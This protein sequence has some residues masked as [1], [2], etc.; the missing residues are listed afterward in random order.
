MIYQGTWHTPVAWGFFCSLCE[1]IC[2]FPQK[3]NSTHVM[4][5]QKCLFSGSLKQTDVSSICQ[6]VTRKLLLLQD[7]ITYALLLRRMLVFC[8]KDTP[9]Y[10]MYFQLYEKYPLDKRITGL[11]GTFGDSLVW[12]IC[13]S[14]VS[15]SRLLWSMSRGILSTSSDGDSTYTLCNVLWCLTTFTLGGKKNLNPIFNQN[16]LYFNLCSTEKSQALSP[17]LYTIRS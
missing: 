17:F 16:F 15:H 10:E 1:N 3:P 8:G 11:E 6:Q 12:F 9:Y 4:Q 13:S 14:R 7:I 2:T 5:E